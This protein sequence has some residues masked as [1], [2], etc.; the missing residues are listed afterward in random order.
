[1]Q[2]KCFMMMVSVGLLV[3]WPNDVQAQGT[4]IPLSGFT[5]EGISG[6][7]VLGENSQG[8]AVLYNDISE[9]TTVLNVPNSSAAYGMSGNYIVGAYDDNNGNTHGFLY[10]ITTGTSITMD[11]PSAYLSPNPIRVGFKDGTEFTGIYGDNIVGNY[12]DSSG[13]EHGLLYNITN[14]TW[15]TLYPG[16][17]GIYGSLV[18]GT[19]GAPSSGFIYNGAT[20]STFMV[21]GSSDTL[22]NGIFGTEIVGTSA[23]G[24][25]PN[26]Y[27]YNIATGT[28]TYPLTLSNFSVLNGATSFEF[29]GIS[30]SSLM[31]EYTYP[32]IGGGS[33]TAY[34]LYTVPEISSMWLVVVPVVGMLRC[35]L[36]RP[37]HSS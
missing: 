36:K 23:G 20:Y 34:F 30:G 35:R 29:T 5:P 21:P 19:G 10:N 37:V 32:R 1:M 26:G 9:T 16:I 24:P 18:I 7:I 3:L 15:A 12:I 25:T 27:V 13:D 28:F 8:H 33:N 22:A 4:L 17:N 11:D 6:N 14:Q 2:R 31:G